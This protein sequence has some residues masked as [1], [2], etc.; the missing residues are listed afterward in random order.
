M[1]SDIF[2]GVQRHFAQRRALNG[3]RRFRTESFR[4]TQDQ[5]LLQ[6][7]FETIVIAL[8][9]SPFPMSLLPLQRQA[10]HTFYNSLNSIELH[11]LCQSTSTGPS[12]PP[13]LGL[14]LTADAIS[15][16]GQHLSLFERAERPEFGRRIRAGAAV[17]LSH[18]P[19]A[20][21]EVVD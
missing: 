3:C 21:T 14:C 12:K 4:L 20:P 9:Y 10:A 2:C 16:L 5:S 18:T 1:L 7:C 17:I 13:S 8:I 19:S 6:S 15:D 11:L